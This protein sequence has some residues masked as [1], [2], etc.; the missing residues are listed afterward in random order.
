M[1]DALGKGIG[2]EIANVNVHC[3]YVWDSDCREAQMRGG[4]VH[5]YCC[6]RIL[7]AKVSHQTRS[8][9]PSSHD[10][11]SDNGRLWMLR[12]RR[13]YGLLSLILWR[14]MRWEIGHWTWWL[15][16]HARLSGVLS[17]LM[18]DTCTYILYRLCGQNCIFEWGVN[19]AN[20][21][22]KSNEHKIHHPENEL[23]YMKSHR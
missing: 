14:V 18:H 5:G 1:R 15:C 21:S 9:F 6:F 23:R 11:S 20:L 13:R 19:S 12:A 3:I 17:L 22:L 8:D 7:C 4:S 16:W 2:K 10:S